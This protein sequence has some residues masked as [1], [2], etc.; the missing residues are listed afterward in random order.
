MLGKRQR[1]G[2][3]ADE[4]GEHP[5]GAPQIDRTPDAAHLALP[6]DFVTSVDMAALFAWFVARSG[7]GGGGGE[8][9]G[10]GTDGGNGKEGSQEGG[11]IRSLH[12]DVSSAGAW[13]PTLGVLGV[14][15]RGL[16]HLRIA[17]DSPQ[18][19]MVGCSAPW[20]ALC[21]NLV[22][23]ELDDVVDQSIGDCTAFPTGLTRLEL[24]YC[25]EEG[26]YSI[27]T[28]LSRC[29]RLHTLTLNCAIFDHDLT[30]DRL[31]A[32][33]TIQCLDLSN[34]CLTRVPPVLASLP[35]LTSLTLND[36]DSLGAS[37]EALAP[38]SL[39]TSLQVLEMRECGLRSVPASLVALPALHS[40]LMGYNFMNERPFL[41]PGPYLANLR[42]LAMSDAKGFQ[43]DSPWDELSEPLVPA[44]ALE[45]LRINRCLGLQLSIEEVE[46]LLAGKPR[47]RKLE[48]TAD[49]LADERDL[50]ELRRR[51]PQVTFKAVE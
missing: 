5:A 7:S 36:N 24:S 31:A 26:L 37:G 15:G 48:F 9:D 3:Y 13:G 22:S 4:G 33:T 41:P 30:L 28:N 25:G 2:S 49:M 51:H 18:C 45:V 6:A 14:V 46:Q 10:G 21:P 40:L 44:A 47:F 16:R 23:L 17:G 39:L 32:C 42:V 27:P 8:A 11:C 19:Q 35:R 50:L 29:T 12:V 20:L 38:L 34:C 43:D 1:S